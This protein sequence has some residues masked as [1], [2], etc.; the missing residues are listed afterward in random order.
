MHIYIYTH[1]YWNHTVFAFCL[2]ML[3]LYH[4]K[5]S[6]SLSNFHKHDFRDNIIIHSP[7]GRK[8]LGTTVR[9]S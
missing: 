4:K 3:T 9:P 6:M 1:K 7:W 8:E 2:F 5:L